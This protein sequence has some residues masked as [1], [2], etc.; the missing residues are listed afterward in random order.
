MTPQLVRRPATRLEALE[1]RVNLSPPTVT[2]LKIDDGTVQR[3]MITSLTITFSEAV[4]ITTPIANAFLLHR[5][6]APPNVPGAEQGGQLGLVNLSA[7]QSGAIVTVTFNTSGP[8]PINAVGGGVGNG[9]SIPDGRYTLTIDATKVSGVA[10]ALDG[11]GDGIGGDNYVL[12]CA[13]AP[14]MPTHIFRF[15]GDAKGD[16]TVS[17]ADFHAMLTGFEVPTTFSIIT[18]TVLLLPA[19]S[20]NSDCD[21][22]APCRDRFTL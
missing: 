5:D 20:L 10:G 1:T 16:G 8:N 14:A 12:A 19:I 17:A 7:V 15:Y 22:A 3:S 9:P 2:N 21:S 11:N 6:S 18:V 4:T 13:P